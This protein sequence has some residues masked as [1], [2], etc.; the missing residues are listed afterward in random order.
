MRKPTFRST[1]YYVLNKEKSIIE[2]RI[3]IEKKS[4]YG[5]YDKKG[6]LIYESKPTASGFNL[7]E[8]LQRLERFDGVKVKMSKK[9]RLRNRK[10]KILMI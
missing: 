7:N 3:V 2:K 6:K 5:K 1:K 4:L 8:K 9:D 10:W